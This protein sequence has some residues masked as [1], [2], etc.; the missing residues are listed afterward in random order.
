MYFIIRLHVCVLKLR[1]WCCCHSYSRL[2][3]TA[4]FNWMQI[5]YAG[6]ISF[7]LTIECSNWST[8]SAQHSHCFR[9]FSSR[10]EFFLFCRLFI[11]ILVILDI[12]VLYPTLP[13]SWI[14]IPFAQ[15]KRK[16]KRILWMLCSYITQ[17][18]N[19]ETM[20][21]RKK[22]VHTYS[23]CAFPSQNKITINT[24]Y[25]TSYALKRREGTEKGKWEREKNRKVASE[26]KD[27]NLNVP[28]TF[29][30]YSR[31]SVTFHTL[32]LRLRIRRL[33]FGMASMVML[34]I[35][36][37]LSSEE[38]VIR[39]KFFERYFRNWKKD[40]TNSPRIHILLHSIGGSFLFFLLE[41]L[42]RCTTYEY[43]MQCVTGSLLIIDWCCVWCV[44]VCARW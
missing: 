42:Q 6:L 26:Q 9:F 27:N 16:K 28:K 5:I 19:T 37:T 35:A 24:P 44:S 40:L 13:R 33:H 18:I 1:R 4:Q 8:V 2:S 41:S 22:S 14:A 34:A 30:S 25:T 39:F 29:F 20:W 15:K 36:V 21:R 11:W 10:S 38:T 31:F 23:L 7:G 12:F 3:D 32:I 17:S 43:N